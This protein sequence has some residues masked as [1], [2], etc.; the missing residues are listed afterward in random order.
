MLAL[1]E[2]CSLMPTFSWFKQPIT[3]L[4]PSFT[5]L[6]NRLT[7]HFLFH[8][9]PQKYQSLLGTCVTL[10]LSIFI[11]YRPSQDCYISRTRDPQVFLLDLVPCRL[12][13]M[14]QPATQTSIRRGCFILLR[15]HC[16]RIVHKMLCMR[17]RAEPC[18]CK[19]M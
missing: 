4:H 15:L 18:A 3:A 8:Q 1:G 2:V 10:A 16:C 9:L 11:P 17:R 14:T 7:T 6:A 13:Q 19:V 12:C 5:H